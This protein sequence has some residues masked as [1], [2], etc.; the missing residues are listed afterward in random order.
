MAAI[1][2]MDRGAAVAWSVGDPLAAA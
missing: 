2:Q 1:A